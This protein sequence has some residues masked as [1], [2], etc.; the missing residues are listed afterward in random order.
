MEPNETNVNQDESFE[1]EDLLSEDVVEEE[2][3]E[4]Q[5]L[6]DVL[7]E[8]GQQGQSGQQGQEGQNGTAGTNEPGYVQRRISKAVEKATASLQSELAS[9]RAQMEPLRE[10]QLTA[11]A[12]ELVRTGKVKDLETAKELVRYRQGQ[13][14]PTS[15]Q[16]EGQPRNAKGQFVSRQDEQDSDPATTARID[17]LQHQANRIKAGNGP[18]VIAEFRE[19]PEI[20]K[21]VIA[22]EMDF[23][24]VADQLR[25][26]AKRKPPSPMRSP[27][28]ASG[29][30]PNAIDTMSDEQFDRMEKRIKEGAR[31]TLK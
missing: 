2:A 21:K 28:G 31:Y 5:D 12:Q 1:A 11:E 22:G 17:M 20:R 16:S 24:D 18:D 29:K 19:N 6:A 4:S 23:Y 9:L 15:E 3:E 10:Y 13:P 25:K 7:S 27:N 8:D 14:Q 26:T 30:N